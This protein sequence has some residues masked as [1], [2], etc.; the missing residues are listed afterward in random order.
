MGK[1]HEELKA[2]HAETEKT[3]RDAIR[4][5]E[6]TLNKAIGG[7]SN[8]MGALVEKFMSAG[9][10]ASRSA[11]SLRICY[12][13]CRT[14]HRRVRRGLQSKPQQGCVMRKLHC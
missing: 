6:E 7:L 13:L 12:S 9:R 2:A 4:S 11:D 14:R 5:T 8:T 1:G 3:L 10:T